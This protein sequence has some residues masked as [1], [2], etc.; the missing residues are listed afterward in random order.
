M[1]KVIQ[2]I[3]TYDRRG[4]GQAEDPF[5]L[6]YQL[7]TLEGVLV[8]EKD[9]YESGEVNVKCSE[10]QCIPGVSGLACARI[11]CGKAGSPFAGEPCDCKCHT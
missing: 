5:R 3:E 11:Q 2:L 6:L 8:F 9:P 1:A 4:T 7:W 10:E